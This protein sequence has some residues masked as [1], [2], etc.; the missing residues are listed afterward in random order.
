MKLEQGVFT[1]SLDFELIWG[2]VDLFGPEAFRR[3]CE[4]ERAEVIDRL[5]ALFTEF[6]VSATW[7]TLGHLFL[8]RCQPVGGVKHPEIVRPRH[9]WQRADWFADDPCGNDEIF[10]GH[11]LIE[12]IRACAVPQEI[13]SHSFSHVIL[14]DAGCSRAT[15]ESELRECVRLAAEQGIELRSFAFPRNAVG[16]L[17][18]LQEQG[19]WCYRGPEPLWYENQAV[20][21]AL[22][23]LLRLKDVLLAVQPPVVLPERTAE[24]L[25]N[26]P[27]SAFYFPMHGLRRFLPL[28][29]RTRRAMKG[30]DA[31]AQTK[32]IFHLWFHPTN[33]AD[34]SERMFAGLRKIFEYAATLRSQGKLQILPMRA[35]AQGS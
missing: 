30:L 13:G 32:R 20:P 27:G 15:A 4:I 1:I 26:L 21:E 10:Y 14:G 33:L 12:K 31:A 24:G 22:R 6:E 25:W 2:T 8:K 5:L 3:A 28:R 9:A 7:C 11:D 17:D 29:L 34:E 19:F 23:R 18:V 35:L 16:H